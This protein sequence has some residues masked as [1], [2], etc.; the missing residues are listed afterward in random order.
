MSAVRCLAMRRVARR[1]FALCS[2]LS[3]PDAVWVGSLVLVL[4]ALCGYCAGWP[5][6]PYGNFFLYGAVGCY[7]AI[8]FH[9]HRCRQR[10]ETR[11]R[12]GLCPVCGYDVRGS[13]E[14]CPECGTAAVSS[15]D[16]G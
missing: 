16:V 5:P 12:R 10:V 3:Q 1:L 14:R 8:L 7:L 4:L 6:K 13:P 11:K 15:G 2:A 9:Q